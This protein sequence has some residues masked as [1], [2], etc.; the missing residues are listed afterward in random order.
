MPWIQKHWC[1]VNAQ[2]HPKALQWGLVFKLPIQN[3]RPPLWSSGQSSWQQ[4]QGSGFDSRRYQIFEEVVCLEWGPLSLVST[5]E[6]LLERK[7]SCSSLKN[8]DYGHRN[9]SRSPRDTLYPQ[10]LAITSPTSGDC[11]V[12]IVRSRTKATELISYI[13]FHSIQP[14]SSSWTNLHICFSTSRLAACRQ[15]AIS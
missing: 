15:H 13:D 11:S 9:P 12:G 8:R 5:I 6:G 2:F 10:K 14:P 1:A 4:I 3:S 7:S